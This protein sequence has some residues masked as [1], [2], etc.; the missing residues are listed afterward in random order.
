V[1]LEILTYYYTNYSDTLTNGGTGTF[2]Y[3]NYS[4]I[5]SLLQL[6]RGNQI[7][8]NILTFT[9]VSQDINQNTGSFYNET[10]SNN[11]LSEISRGT[12]F[13]ATSPQITNALSPTSITVTN[14]QT[15]Q[16]WVEAIGTQPLNYQWQYS[17]D[18]GTNWEDLIDSVNF[19]GSTTSNVLAIQSA[20]TNDI[21]N[22]QVVVYNHFGTVTSDVFSVTMVLAPQITAQPANQVYDATNLLASFT[23]SAIGYQPLNYQWYWGADSSSVTN[24]LSNGSPFTN[25]SYYAQ[26]VINTTNLAIQSIS[27]TNFTASFLVNISNDFGSTNSRVAT[28]K[29][30]TS[31]TTPPGP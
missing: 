26:S 4:P 18:N 17:S 10:Y 19:S 8:Y 7:D 29:W 30:S 24:P 9:N 3:T 16:M 6:T 31:P 12:F 14:G 13:V 23:V 28:I 11:V 22:Y 5:G 21:G 1:F 2:T 15:F 27:S 20:T 25:G